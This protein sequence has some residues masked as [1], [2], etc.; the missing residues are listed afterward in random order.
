MPKDKLYNA[1]QRM[2]F[3][4]LKNQE[5][6]INICP[7]N[8][9]KKSRSFVANQMKMTSR[10]LPVIDENAKPDMKILTNHHGKIKDESSSISFS[11][12]H[13]KESEMNSSIDL[14]GSFKTL[15]AGSVL[16]GKNAKY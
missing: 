5:F 12:L 16:Y 15:P 11:K 6:D 9:V 13:T 8:T 4:D 14:N 1:F 7:D 10:I 2:S 3:S